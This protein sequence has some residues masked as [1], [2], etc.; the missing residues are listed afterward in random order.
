MEFYKSLPRVVDSI[1]LLVLQGFCYH[2]TLQQDHYDYFTECVI[3]TEFY[4]DFYIFPYYD[5]ILHYYF[6]TEF[7]FFNV[8]YK[9][10]RII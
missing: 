8:F 4:K 3:F 5:T 9:G 6:T 1:I 7:M 2:M 10:F